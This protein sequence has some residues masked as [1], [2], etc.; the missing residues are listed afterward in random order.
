MSLAAPAPIVWLGTRAIAA[1]ATVAEVLGLLYGA[2]VATPVLVRGRGLRVLWQVALEQLRY[3]GVQAVPITT[4][5]SLALGTLIL[6]QATKYVP[7]D[8]APT[9][10]ATI[11]VR[12]VIPL[13][14]AMVLIGRSATAISVELASMRLSGQ[15]HALRAMGMAIEHVI[16]LPRLI[17]GVVSG[18]CL[19][20]LGLTTALV[21]GYGLARMVAPIPFPLGTALDAVELHDAA[22]ALVKVSLFGAG[23]ILVAVRE[24]LIVRVSAAE[25]PRAATRAAVRGVGLCVVLNSF[26]SLVA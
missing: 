11:L 4:L 22:L 25:I 18:V 21:L 5:A 9:V 7:A 1:G 8:Y 19:S 2:L 16:V 6:T 15:I 3:T 10:S 13:I 24:G 17:A 14:V 12:E 20:V 23:V 26:L